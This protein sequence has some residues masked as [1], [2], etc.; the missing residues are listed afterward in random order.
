MSIALN[1]RIKQLEA[2]VAELCARVAA[3]EAK[4]KPGRPPKE[5]PE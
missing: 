3:L 5:K 4:P 1:Q 2:L